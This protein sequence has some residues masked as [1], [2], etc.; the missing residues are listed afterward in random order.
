MANLIP[1]FTE[2]LTL[3]PEGSHYRFFVHP[4]IGYGMEG[5]ESI[6]PNTLLIFDVELH[7]IVTE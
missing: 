6:P 5:T 7:E 3:M 2:G 1:G 4:D